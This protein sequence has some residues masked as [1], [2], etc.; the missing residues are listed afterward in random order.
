MRLGVRCGPFWASFGGRC[1]RGNRTG[2][3][4]AW[5]I[6]CLMALNWWNHTLVGW[7]WVSGV[8]VLAVLGW[9]AKATA[10]R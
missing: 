5:C 7:L 6:F 3:F 1:G 2:L 8:A 10:R 9:I 4:G